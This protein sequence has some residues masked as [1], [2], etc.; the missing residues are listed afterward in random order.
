[1]VYFLYF[2]LFLIYIYLGRVVV[3]IQTVCSKDGGEIKEKK[4]TKAEESFGFCD[5][6][7]LEQC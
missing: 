2:G 3:N 1:M 5:A 4:K 6:L 7:L